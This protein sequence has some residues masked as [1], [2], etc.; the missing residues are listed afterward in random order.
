MPGSSE[1]GLGL[2]RGG[3]S[4][5]GTER[6]TWQVWNVHLRGEWALGSGPDSRPLAVA[7]V[8]EAGE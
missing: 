3:I 5:A 2:L 4:S 7:W 6:G 1:V 8:W